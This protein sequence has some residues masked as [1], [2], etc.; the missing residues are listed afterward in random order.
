MY[1]TGNPTNNTDPTG[2]LTCAFVQI[3][4]CE[5]TTGGQATPSAVTDANHEA[6]QMPGVHGGTGW[7]AGPNFSGG[8]SGSNADELWNAA[9]EEDA[10]VS[11]AT[12]YQQ[13]QDEI[14]QP[15]PE[16]TPACK[17]IDGT[18][19]AED[20]APTAEDTE[21]VDMDLI[22]ANNQGKIDTL[23]CLLSAGVMCEDGDDISI[24]RPEI[25]GFYGFAG[26][27]T[28]HT[29]EAEGLYIGGYDFHEGIYGGTLIGGGTH[30]GVIAVEN[31]T[32]A[33]GEE[34][35]ETLAMVEHSIGTKGK[36]EYG[37]GGFLNLSSG[38]EGGIF[39]YGAIGPVTAGVGVSAETQIS[40]DN[41]AKND[42]ARA[43]V[44]LVQTQNTP[45]RESKI[46]QLVS[47]W[48]KTLGVY[49]Y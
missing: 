6:T 11:D 32:L 22:Y 49:Q 2:Y 45:Q 40:I 7:G 9:N 13:R 37:I 46:S 15:C 44:Q 25:T 34:T 26:G 8:A 3:G 29:W 16:K 42:A 31:L 20:T 24:S 41:I 14:N 47:S 17:D 27:T 1:V 10:A 33:S 18:P 30:G 35:S 28:G 12:G 38:R 4:T 19:T 39:A 48:A 21:P 43:G 36:V 23:L 5:N